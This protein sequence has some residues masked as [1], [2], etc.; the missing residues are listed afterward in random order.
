[1]QSDGALICKRWNV[2]I[3]RYAKA[4]GLT[5]GWGGDYAQCAW[6]HD[7]VQIACR[8]REITEEL[9]AFYKKALQ[10]AA[11]GFKFHFPLDSDFSIGI[12]WS[13]TH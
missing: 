8:T 5:H 3:D 10:Q 13:E 1:M 11:E 6:V 9:G 2:L 4:K 12:N 7:E